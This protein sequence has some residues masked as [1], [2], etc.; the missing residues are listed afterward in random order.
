ME[1]LIEQKA[2]L[3]G[4]L[5]LFTQTFYK[6]RTGRDFVL[7]KPVSRESHQITICRELV[8]VFR[9]PDHNLLINVPPGHGKSELL[10][11][12]IAWS[13]AHYPDCQFLYISYSSDLAAKHTYT[14]KQ[15]MQMPLY[16]K[17]FGFGIKRDSSAKD[18]FKTT[19]G[20]AVMAF[21]SSGS[22]TGQDGGL[23][24]LERF[25]GA[26]IMDDMH[27]PQEVHSDTIRQTVKD[28]YLG[29]ILQRLRGNR[30]PL[31]FLGQ[32]LHE[33]DLAMNIRAGFDELD[34]RKVVL[35]SRDSAGNILAPNIIS[36]ERL[37]KLE[38][39][40][41]YVYA[42]QYQQEPQPAGGGIFKPEWF[43]L[44]DD[45]PEFLATFI[46]ADTAETDK[47]YNDPSVFSFWG[48]YKITHFDT[49]TD[50]Y[51]LH[52]I[53]CYEEWIDAKDLENEFTQF[54]AESMR[55]PVKPSAIAIE[56][57]STGVTLLSA[58]KKIQG[59]RVID[60]ER[61]KASGSKTTRFL[62]M[63]P[64]IAS[65]LVS[66]P[67]YGKHTHACIEHMRK[68]TANDTHRHDDR[69][70][71]LY[72]AVKIALIDKLITYITANKSESKDVIKSLVNTFNKRQKMRSRASWHNR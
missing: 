13:M 66:L 59:L 67:R 29:T 41:P 62:E 61:T 49:D 15:I 1:N 69:A 56:K 52:W 26:V 33:D 46:T 14:I 70:D 32:V 53:D 16:Q 31:I 24:N 19:Q 30:V 68:I 47:T 60:V 42:A 28:N 4:S 9:N 27:K 3:L 43:E 6:L 20:G 57:K 22:I 39:V 7:A 2:K 25:S 11:H 50:L 5:L 65:K 58:I 10:I 55:H 63:Q 37:E 72:D 38:R 54:L 8:D 18:N 12:F 17:I 44:K 35:K 48:I 64:I 71:T 40:S 34:W 21:G 51:G 45:E 23:P 36:K